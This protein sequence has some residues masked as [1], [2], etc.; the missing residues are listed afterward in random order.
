MEKIDE[1]SGK[2]EVPSYTKI[3]YEGYNV[4]DTYN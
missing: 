4:H 3:K 2:T 1:G